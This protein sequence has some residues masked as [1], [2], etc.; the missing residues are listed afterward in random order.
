[1]N[2]FNWDSSFLVDFDKETGISE[3]AE[4]TYRTLSQMKSMYQDQEAVKE[5][6]EKEDPVIYEFYELGC[7]EREGDLAFGTTIIH[8][9]KIGNE[10]YMTKGHFHN[11]L[12]TAEVYYALRGQGFMMMEN[13]AGDWMAEPLEPGKVTYVPRGYAHRTINTGEEDLVAFFVFGA[14]AGHDYGTIET[15]GYR[16]ILVDEGGIPTTKVNPKWEEK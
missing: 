6:L 3:H 9:G 4:R 10:Y 2:C 11:I 1:M 8:S 15:K 7:P 13:L 16:H 14:D 5:I 12:D